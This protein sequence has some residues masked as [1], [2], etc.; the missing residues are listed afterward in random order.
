MAEK[1][2]DMPHKA[3]I[4]IRDQALN[5]SPPISLRYTREH[6]KKPRPKNPSP[7]NKI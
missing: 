6:A 7:I 2:E 4:T 1:R 5:L 3:N